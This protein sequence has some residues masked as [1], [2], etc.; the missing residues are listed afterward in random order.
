M[1]KWLRYRARP[2][3]A[4]TLRAELNR[5]EQDSAVLRDKIVGISEH[6]N[7]LRQQPDALQAEIEALR[8]IVGK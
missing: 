2:E 5:L 3:D 1:T 6:I 4:D 8:I 7:E